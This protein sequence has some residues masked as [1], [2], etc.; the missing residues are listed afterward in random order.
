MSNNNSEWFLDI[1]GNPLEVGNCVL[2]C[3][4]NRIILGRITALGETNI[5]VQP[6][7]ADAKKR[8]EIPPQ[9]PLRRFP[10]NVYAVN[11]KEIFWAE[12]KDSL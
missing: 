9:K 4:N 5:M 6:L 11:P 3:Q 7:E 8:R 2:T 1:T 10:Y 12:L